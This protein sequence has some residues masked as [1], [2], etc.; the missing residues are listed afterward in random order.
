MNRAQRL[1]K[2]VEEGESVGTGAG[3]PA[4]TNNLGVVPNPVIGAV[5]PNDSKAAWRKR[6]KKSYKAKMILPDEK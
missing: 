1:I 2:L 6:R 5:V 4:S 3:A